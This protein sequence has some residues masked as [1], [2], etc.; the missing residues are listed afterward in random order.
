MRFILIILQLLYC[1]SCTAL[2]F[3]AVNWV[4]KSPSVFSLP[5]WSCVWKTSIF[6]SQK[7][8]V[9]LRLTIILYISLCFSCSEWLWKLFCFLLTKNW[10]SGQSKPISSFLL[11]PGPC[12]LPFLPAIPW[13]LSSTNCHLT[14]TI[15]FHRL[16]QPFFSEPC[17][18]FQQRWQ[19]ILR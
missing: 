6:F 17:P 10:S 11:W 18:F 13:C 4:I 2:C 7:C 5:H 1:R 12:F 14:L 8:G 16:F 15:V 3:S 19:Y 9:S